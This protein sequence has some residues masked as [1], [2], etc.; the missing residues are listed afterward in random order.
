MLLI[1]TL[2]QLTFYNLVAMSEA[3]YL[4]VKDLNKVL[5]EATAAEFEVVNLEK[6]TSTKIMT[7]HG[8]VDF[9]TLTVQRARQLVNRK[10]PFLKVKETSKTSTTKA[11]A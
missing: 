6:R 7:I 1:I 10:V 3:K 4:S 8:E 11:N 9:T 5:P 2:E